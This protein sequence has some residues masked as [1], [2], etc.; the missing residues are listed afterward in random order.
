MSAL[1]IAEA[2]QSRQLSSLEA[3]EYF[4]SR[5]HEFNS[6]T[7][8]FAYVNVKRA[9]R[10]AKAADKVLQ[11]ARN[12]SRLPLFHGVPSAV[13]DLVPTRGVRTQLG[14][15]AFAYFIPPFDG[16]VARRMKEGGFISLGNWPLR[17]LA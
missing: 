7:G 14:S 10:Q 4:L 13:K 3:T 1:E 12:S 11:R 6:Q 15:R 16:L 5:I 8:A 17:N 9:R 2:I